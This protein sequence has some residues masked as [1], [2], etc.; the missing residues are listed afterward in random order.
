MVAE[1]RIFFLGALPG[2]SGRLPPFLRTYV[3]PSVPRAG[4][5]RLVS[6]PFG[7]RAAPSKLSKL[8]GQ[9][10][11][12]KLALCEKTNVFICFCEN[13]IV[14]IFSVLLLE[15]PSGLMKITKNE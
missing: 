10:H 12:L 14:C 6:Q 5:S 13:R 2:R 7:V 9:M 4:P 8:N 1:R 15:A 3:R 11:L